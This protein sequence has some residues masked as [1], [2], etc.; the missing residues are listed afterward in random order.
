MVGGELASAT[1]M[2]AQLSVDGRVFGGHAVGAFLQ[3]FALK[4]ENPSSLF[5]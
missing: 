3:S 5:M 2:T 4:L 1:V